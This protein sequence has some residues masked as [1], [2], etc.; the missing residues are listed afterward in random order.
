MAPWSN[1]LPTEMS[2]PKQVAALQAHFAASC[3]VMTL[4][5]NGRIL[6]ILF[7]QIADSVWQKEK[8]LQSLQTQ[9]MASF[10]SEQY[11]CRCSQHVGIAF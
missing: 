11:D 10:S 7:L 6:L 9:D 2:T 5:P 3:A 4:A 8:K 1:L